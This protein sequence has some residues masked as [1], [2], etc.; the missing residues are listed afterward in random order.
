MDKFLGTLLDNR[1][2]IESVVGEG[3]MATVYK[4]WDEVAEKYVAVKI[5]KEEFAKDFKFRKKFQNESKAIGILSNKNIVEVTDVS[6]TGEYNYIVMELINGRTLKE[7]ID[8]K[9]PLN[10]SEAI[11]YGGQ[12]LGALK[13]AHD[14]G[15]VH[16]DVKPQN[17]MHKFQIIFELTLCDLPHK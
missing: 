12:I 13:H 4:A 10:V 2:Q 6:F 17:I 1:Y 14:K 3:G 8:E 9:A 7:I 15:I 5:L 11:S 16:R